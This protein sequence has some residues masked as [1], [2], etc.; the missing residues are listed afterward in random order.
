MKTLIDKVFLKNRD[1][2]AYEDADLFH[3]IDDTN[4]E[5]RTLKYIHIQ[6][7]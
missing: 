1:T 2:D 5:Q 6:P 7:L 4:L 3:G